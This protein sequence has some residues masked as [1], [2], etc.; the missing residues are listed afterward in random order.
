[1]TAWD[2]SAPSNFKLCKAASRSSGRNNLRLTPLATSLSPRGPRPR[3]NSHRR[4]TAPP[5][6]DRFFTLAG[7]TQE[8]EWRKELD[9]FPELLRQAGLPD[10]VLKDGHSWRFFLQEGCFVWGDDYRLIDATTFLPEEQLVALYDLLCRLLTDEQR[11]GSEL[12]V[13]LNSRFRKS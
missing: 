7:R 12:W 10:A 5:P 13:K 1:M 2:S 3:H 4:G 9:R 8:N 11:T 6:G